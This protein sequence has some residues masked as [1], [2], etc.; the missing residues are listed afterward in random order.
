MT[1]WEETAR[2]DFKR[3]RFKRPLILQAD[4]KRVA[5]TR[6]TTFVGAP[7]DTYN[8]EKWKM[9]QVALGL[10]ARPD[11]V[12][13]V[14]AHRDDKAHLNKVCDT[15]LEVAGSSAAA[16][17]GTAIH[18]FTE[19]IDSGRELPAGLDADTR[20]CLDAYSAAMAPFKVHGIEVQVVSDAL[21]LAGTADRLIS[22]RGNRYIAD[23]KTGSTIE[24]GTGKIAGQLAAYAH[25]RPYDVTSEARLEGHGASV[26]WGLVIHL[27]ADKP[28]EVSLYWVNLL[29]GWAWVI[30]ARQVRD[31]R[32][33][34]FKAWTKP[35]ELGNRPEP[36]KA[37]KDAALAAE[38]GEIERIQRRAEIV[39][40]INASPTADIIRAVWRR[41]A[42]DWDDS[43]TAVA[44]ERIGEIGEGAA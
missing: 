9:R 23:L 13:D 36:T 38:R 34:N 3:D 1:T 7:E 43:L 42:G 8:L 22:Y 26:S 33:H 39:K 20:K 30:V 25:S 5:Y 10:A 19:L 17:R 31:Q 44:R 18:A 4:G 32:A 41:Y 16:T 15:A 14:S 2:P 21:R 11:L 12:L 27:P 40:Q 29:M 28:G 37:D 24:L 35:F 6:V